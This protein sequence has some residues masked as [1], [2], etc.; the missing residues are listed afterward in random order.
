MPSLSG[1]SY[2]VDAST[3]S[4][5]KLVRGPIGTN[6]AGAQNVIAEQIIGFKVG[7]WNTWTNN[8][9]YDASATK[10]AGGYG[11][12]WTSIK[13]VRIDLTARTPINSDPAILSE[14]DSTEV[15][16]RYRRSPWL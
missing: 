4:N 1:I 2:G 14:M 7:V 16:T 5:P 12:D 15:R 8:Y 13:A 9:Y 10:A 6:L 11:S 3:P